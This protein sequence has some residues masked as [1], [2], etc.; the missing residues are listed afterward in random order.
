MQQMRIYNHPILGDMI[1]PKKVKIIVDGKP[2]EAFLGEPIATA[3][4]A[5]GIK[6]FHRSVKRNEP[7]GYFCAI[8]VCNDCIMNVNGQ[9]NVRTCITPVD[10]GMIIQTQIGKGKWRVIK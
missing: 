7:R 8:G 3:L 2:L 9:P 5:A 6:I 1:E 4:I 10:D